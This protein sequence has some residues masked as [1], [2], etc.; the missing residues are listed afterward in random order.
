MMIERDRDEEAYWILT[1]EE[2]QRQRRRRAIHT[3]DDISSALGSHSRD[4]ER[5]ASFVLEGS[6]RQS[7]NTTPSS[8]RTSH[9][10]SLN[11]IFVIK[12]PSN[13]S[14]RDCRT[15][16]GL[17]CGIDGL[18]SFLEIYSSPQGFAG[19]VS[20]ARITVVISACALSSASRRRLFPT[21]VPEGRRGPLQYHA[22]ATG[23]ADARIVDDGHHLC[24][25]TNLLSRSKSM[26][27][28]FVSHKPTTRKSLIVLSG[29]VVSPRQSR[30][31]IPRGS[32]GLGL[33]DRV[34]SQ[35]ATVVYRV[36]TMAQLN[37]KTQTST[38]LGFVTSFGSSSTC[39]IGHTTSGQGECVF[40]V[41]VSMLVSRVQ[42]YGENLNGEPSGVGMVEGPSSPLEG[43]GAGDF[44]AAVR[45][46]IPQDR[47]APYRRFSSGGRILGV[48]GISTPMHSGFTYVGLL[49]DVGIYEG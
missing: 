36:G 1:G 31:G 43:A 20:V 44:V 7:R 40:P 11:K 35:M 5:Q 49:K 29:E 9:K 6:F 8:T 19:G 23:N 4:R 34:N 30:C 2:R 32:P 28:L 13:E 15:L 3:L 21:C 27:G 37:A 22:G 26:H 12:T 10:E 47:G 24:H 48:L 14:R 45:S 16:T 38:W 41:Y 33:E 39:G 17:A 18:G 25:P 42:Q 46:I